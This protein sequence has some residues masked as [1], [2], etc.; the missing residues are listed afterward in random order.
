MSGIATP[1]SDFDPDL[2][3]Q[4]AIRLIFA[5]FRELGSARQVLM[6]LTAEGI[7]LPAPVGRQAA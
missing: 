2:R 6:A 7:H 1:A 4:Q 3:L 5:R